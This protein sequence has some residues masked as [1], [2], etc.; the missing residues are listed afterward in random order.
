MFDHIRENL[1]KINKNISE[2]A[3]RSGRK[4]EEITLVAVSKT[5][6]A[7]AITAAV[8]FGIADV[9]ESRVQEAEPKIQS[10]GKIA[11]WHMIGHLQTNKAKKAVAVFDFIQSVDSLKLAEEINRQAGEINR[12]IDCLIEINSAG[13]SSKSGLAPEMA[14]E[15]IEKAGKLENIILRGIMT[16][17]PLTDDRQLIRNAFR[18]TRRLFEDGRKS[19][20]N[21]FDTLSMGMSDDYEIAIEEGSNMV[22]IGTAIFGSRNK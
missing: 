1:E 15:L 21:Q 16:I 11:R 14:A 17:G 9:G 19:A 13:E 6:P 10:L 3:R 2:A 4:P 18:K 7:E 12:K 5:Y 20:G 8:G 22:R